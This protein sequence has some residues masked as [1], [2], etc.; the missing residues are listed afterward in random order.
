MKLPEVLLVE[1]NDGDIYLIL[2]VLSENKIEAQIRLV[3][4]GLEALDYLFCKGK[5]ESASKPDL[6]LLDMN[7]PVYSGL[8]VLSE[9]KESDELKNIPVV[10]FSTSEYHEDIKKAYQRHCNSYIVKPSQVEIFQ[11][12]ILKTLDYWL[13]L[14][15]LST[16]NKADEY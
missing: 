6:I 7:I 4:N 8:E 16:L 15:T 5:F 1:D 11:D 9:I 14:S 13:Q 12:L 2:E 10:M 3:K